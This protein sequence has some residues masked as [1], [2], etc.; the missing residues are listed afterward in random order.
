MAPHNLLDLFFFL[1]GC[2][3]CIGIT[4]MILSCCTLESWNYSMA[5]NCPHAYKERHGS[6]HEFT[7]V[8]NGIISVSS[9]SQPITILMEKG[10]LNVIILD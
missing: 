10:V 7:L 6:V 5:S 4:G 9:W 1:C 8:P 2:A 3:L